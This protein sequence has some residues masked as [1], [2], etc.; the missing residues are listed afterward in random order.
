MWTLSTQSPNY[1]WKLASNGSGTDFE[2]GD[3]VVFD[4][5]AKGTTVVNISNGDVTPAS[6]TFNN[7]V[8]SY[9][10]TGT[11]AIA[12][13]AILTKNGSGTLTIANANSYY[14][15]TTVNSGGLNI[16]NSE[17]LGFAS[18]GATL[19]INGGTIDN[20][21]GGPLTTDNY[22][23]TWNGNFTFRGSNPLN[24]GNGG[25]TLAA[26]STSISRPARSRWTAPFRAPS[27]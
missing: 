3:A 17:A 11:N 2:N 26:N 6:I 24:L 5:S 14:G 7:N 20:T 4:D 13:N 10:L 22:P 9:T 19:T 16:A 8:L 12:G 23:M 21:S 15:G 25:V 27:A 18:Y 1:N